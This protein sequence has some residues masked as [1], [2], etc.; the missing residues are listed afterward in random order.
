MKVELK[1]DFEISD[2]ACKA[3]MGKTLGE[4]FAWIDQE[5]AGMGRRDTIQAVYNATGRGA[6]LWWPTTIWVEYEAS[7]G[8]VKKDGLAEGYTI[9]S[10]KTIAAP[11]DAIY[12][13]MAGSAKEGDA[14]SDPDG[15]SGEWLRLRPGKDVRLNWKTA[16]VETG[17]MVDCTFVDKGKGKTL[18][19]L[20]HSKIQSRA[21]ADGL[22]NAWGGFFTDLKAG[23]ES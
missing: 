21:E 13:L 3:A 20:T 10:T 22:R 14:Y 15:N 1:P 9:C 7:K 23:L 17:T 5:C 2:A 8:I 19:T 18:A 12:A 4:W 11:V 16:G 6:D